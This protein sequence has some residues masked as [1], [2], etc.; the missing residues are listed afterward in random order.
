M[1]S[2][3][4]NDCIPWSEYQIIYQKDAST[5]LRDLSCSSSKKTG[6]SSKT[7]TLPP[8]GQ[9]RKATEKPS[10][11]KERYTS[12]PVLQSNQLDTWSELGVS[13]DLLSSHSTVTRLQKWES[14]VFAVMEKVEVA[15]RDRPNANPTIHLKDHILYINGDFCKG[16]CTCICIIE[17]MFSRGR[18]YGGAI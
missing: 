1:S 13:I 3:P 11:V 14:T 5:L 6:I 9:R 7:S 8:I 10:A 12:L 18:Q 17:M 2:I 4:S 15:Y 16:F